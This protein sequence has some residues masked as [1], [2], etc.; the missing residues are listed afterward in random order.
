MR[1]LQ[2]QLTTPNINR[3]FRL[4]V[5][6]RILTVCT[7]DTYRNIQDFEWLVDT[8]IALIRVPD[9]SESIARLLSSVMIDVAVRVADVRTYMLAKLLNLLEDCQW[10]YIGADECSLIA[11]EGLYWVIGEFS[12]A[13]DSAIALPA[14]FD[15]LL[16]RNNFAKLPESTQGSALMALVKYLARWVKSQFSPDT[17]LIAGLRKSLEEQQTS[18]HD[19][20]RLALGFLLNTLTMLLADQS[21]ANVDALVDIFATQLNPVASDAQLQVSVPPSLDL[22]QWIGEPWKSETNV[23]VHVEEQP[24]QTPI[25]QRQQREQLDQDAAHAMQAEREQVRRYLAL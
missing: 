12:A 13:G 6:Q 21:K 10:M 16:R 24:P 17:E 2:Q 22:D 11:L 4:D 18:M 19:S 5:M 15:L 14:M 1:R 9:G 23:T 7:Q 20:Q 8:L 3:A 25:E